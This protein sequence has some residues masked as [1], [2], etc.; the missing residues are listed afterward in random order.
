MR[1]PSSNA[2]SLCSLTR[3]CRPCPGVYNR[4]ALDGF[5]F[6]ISEMGKRGMHATVVVGNEWAWSGGSAQLVRWAEN[7][8]GPP[9]AAACAAQPALQPDIGNA[10]WRS[11]GFE[12]IPYPGP[13]GNSWSDYQALSGKLYTM[14]SVR[15][16]WHMYRVAH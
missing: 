4:D 12:N 1:R 6:L 9:D 15:H 3:G 11:H 13:G 10:S 14:P 2:L 16:C 8:H 7:S 5:D